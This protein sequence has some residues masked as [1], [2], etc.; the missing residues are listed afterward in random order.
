MREG[1]RIGTAHQAVVREL[2]VS[3]VVDLSPVLRRVVF[4]GDDLR[5]VVMADGQK[6]DPMRSAGFDDR[7]LIILPDPDTGETVLPVQRHGRIE[8]RPDGK[9]GVRRSYTVRSWDAESGLLSIDFVLHGH[10]PAASW[11]AN[12]DPGDRLHVLGPGISHAAPSNVDW[13]LIAGDETALPAIAR[14]LEESPEDAVGD[15]FIE[16]DRPEHRLEIAKPAGVSVTWLCRDGK[17]ASDSS[18][19]ADAIIALPWRDGTCYAWVAAETGVVRPIRRFLR[20]ERGL[21]RTQVEVAGYWRQGA[22]EGQ[23][24]HHAEAHAESSDESG[25]E[26]SELTDSLAGL[27]GALNQLGVLPEGVSVQL[28]PEGIERVRHE[29]LALRPDLTLVS[30]TA[31]VTVLV[32][33]DE[34]AHAV[35]ERT[36]AD[37]VT[38]MQDE[39]TLIVVSSPGVSFAIPAG[40][41]AK[42]EH[43]L[44]WLGTVLV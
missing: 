42:N 4:E 30:E 29:L 12:C 36:L 5:G 33:D 13:H 32:L 28:L 31:D 8:S 43:H 27:S 25:P 17:P 20:T 38:L 39:G 10:G 26:I 3:D 9:V 16:I 1:L 6:L 21:P 37:A 15:V 22:A 7:L 11:A 23:E 24:H 34:M 44:D 2:V 40:L 41:T 14:W 18:L 19:L 35:R